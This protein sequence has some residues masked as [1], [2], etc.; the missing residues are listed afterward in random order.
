MP[1]IQLLQTLFYHV[2][3]LKFIYVEAFLIQSTKFT[4]LFYD[5][6]LT[7]NF[8]GMSFGIPFI[9]SGDFG[10]GNLSQSDLDEYRRRLGEN[11]PTPQDA[12]RFAGLQTRLSNML[13]HKDNKVYR[14]AILMIK[15]KQGPPL[16]EDKKSILEATIKTLEAKALKADKTKIVEKRAEKENIDGVRVRLVSDAT[17]RG[18]VVPEE[19]KFYDSE[20]RIFKVKMDDGATTATH[21]RNELQLICAKCNDKDGTSRCSRCRYQPYCGVVCQRE[22]WAHHKLICKQ[23]KKAP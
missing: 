3:L 22:D 2:L 23:Y 13:S 14:S 5:T 8:G 1:A 19:W 21:S 20:G 11:S 9:S 16:S 7:M 6:I 17:K 12:F 18:V 15:G 4:K 10:E